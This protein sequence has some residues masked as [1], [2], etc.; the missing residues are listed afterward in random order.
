MRNRTGNTSSY[1]SDRGTAIDFASSPARAPVQL[2][3]SADDL[4][5][6]VYRRVPT[7]SERVGNE[8]QNPP[9]S[10]DEGGF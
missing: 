2:R 8:T 3:R 7:R 4:E 10:Q 5:A 1:S 9:K 6:A